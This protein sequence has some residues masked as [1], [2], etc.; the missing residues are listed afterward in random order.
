[1]KILTEFTS[2]FFRKIEDHSC[3]LHGIM[4][5]SMGERKKGR[6]GKGGKGKEGGKKAD[7]R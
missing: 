7:N 3:V 6:Q 4:N 2:I 1:M 5:Q